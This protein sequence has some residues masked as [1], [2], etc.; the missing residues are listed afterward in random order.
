VAAWVAEAEA[1]LGALREAKQQHGSALAEAQAQLQ[2]CTAQCAS[3][4]QVLGVRVRVR[5]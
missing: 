1:Q 4:E 5:P 2:S 3:T